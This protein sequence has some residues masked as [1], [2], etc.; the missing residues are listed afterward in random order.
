MNSRPFYFVG[1]RD[2]H[3][4]TAAFGRPACGEARLHNAQVTELWG[5]IPE[6]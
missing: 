4:G 6:V 1:S 5:E 2:A 3:V